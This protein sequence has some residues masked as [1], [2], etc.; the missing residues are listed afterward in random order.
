MTIIANILNLLACLF[1]VLLFVARPD[2]GWI[3]L[4][5][6]IL[7]QFLLA[8]FVSIYTIRQIGT[9]EFYNGGVRVTSGASEIIYDRDEIDFSM[10]H[11]S[12]YNKEI[13]WFGDLGG[14]LKYFDIFNKRSKDFYDF[15]ELRGN[16][17]LFMIRNKRELN[18]IKSIMN[19]F[20]NT[21]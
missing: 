21:N 3:L 6:F 17:L 18:S 9:I 7:F 15:I 11:L 20:K 10:F 4:I 8:W 13:K 1:F 12:K 19:S 16:R 2:S 5:A 14:R